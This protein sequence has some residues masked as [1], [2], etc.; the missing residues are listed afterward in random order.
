[1]DSAKRTVDLDFP[2][3]D[4]ISPAR[5]LE[6]KGIE[7]IKLNLGDPLM[8]DFDT[9]RHMKE[10]VMEEM[11]RY[12][13]YENPAGSLKLREAIVQR[14]KKK[15]DLDIS[16]NDVIIT[17]GTSESIQ[18]V[19]GALLNP[20]DEILVPGPTYPP[21]IALS[22][23]FGAKPIPYRTIEEENWI[24]DLE[25]MRKKINSKTKGIV[26]INP[27]NPTGALYNEQILRKIG[28]IVAEYNIVLISDE[29]YDNIVYEKKHYSPSCTK[30]IPLIIFNG[31]SK[32]YLSTGWR[33]GWTIF[34]DHNEILNEIKNGCLKQARI[35]VSANTVMQKGAVSGLNGPQDHIRETRLKLKKRR[36]YIFKRLN[37]IDGISTQKP[38]GTFYIFPKIEG[39]H[40]D[41]KAFVLKVL[42]E[43]HILLVHGSGFCP[44]YGKGH[45]RSIFLPNIETI[46]KSMD[47][48]EKTLKKR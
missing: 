48:L 40:I 28:D 29:I 17:H 2:I 3:G 36:D 11:K 32:T 5:K 47:A 43:A 37:D 6:E 35:R 15:N 44:I 27:N 20:G 16:V 12:N 24:P 25:D 33:V 45:F 8:F 34:R 1:M 31:I 19:Y 46:K 13:G 4:V 39:N 30:E 42:S 26:L 7:I 41:D 10:T 18:I 22:K 21:Y 14:E 23:F 9:P 38:E